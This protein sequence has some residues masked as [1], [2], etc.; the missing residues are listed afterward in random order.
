MRLLT[1]HKILISAALG[2][3]AIL[4]V[5][6]IVHGR[7]GEPG[8]WG[9]FALGAAMIPLGILYLRKLLRNPPIR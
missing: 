3:G 7:R 1:A 8:A 2:L 5:W 9:V 6:G 4:A